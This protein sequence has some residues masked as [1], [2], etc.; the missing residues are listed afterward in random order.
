VQ[1][2]PR[3]LFILVGLMLVGGAPGS[4][5]GGIKITTVSVLLAGVWSTLRGRAETTLLKRRVLPRQHAEAVAVAVLA[6]L[7]IATVT[8]G[9][10]LVE[11]PHLRAPLLNLLFEVTSAV[12]TVGLSAVAAA[13]ALS[14]L[15]LVLTMFAGRLGPITLVTALMERPRATPYRLPSDS[16]RIG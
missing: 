1:S 4:M 16:V 14:K 5:A 6:L 7:L 9:I 3:S 2:D 15:L 10:S 13:S 8:L 12:G 11:G